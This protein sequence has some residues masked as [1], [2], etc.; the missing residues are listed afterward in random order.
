MSRAPKMEL[1]GN[2]PIDLL[3]RRFRAAFYLGGL[4][5]P[6][7]GLTG[8]ESRRLMVEFREHN[9]A[10]GMKDGP[11]RAVKSLLRAGGKDE[12]PF[13][14]SGTAGMESTANFE[15]AQ[16]EQLVPDARVG[17]ESITRIGLTRS[18]D[19]DLRR[20]HEAAKDTLAAYVETVAGDGTPYLWA[21][22]WPSAG[23][24][25][26][27]ISGYIR[28]PGEDARDPYKHPIVD[29]PELGADQI[30]PQFAQQKADILALLQTAAANL[31]HPELQLAQ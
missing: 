18:T 3:P 6:E 11:L 28:R 14:V 12:G 21:V 16:L 5:Y 8:P 27:H 15:G 4:W 1:H 29:E 22:T 23:Q 30:E 17:G 25:E 7:R 19:A 26:S 31:P 9:D 24:A 20:P 10:K 2:L 13:R